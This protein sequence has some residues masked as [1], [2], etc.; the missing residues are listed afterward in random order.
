MVPWNRIECWPARALMVAGRRTPLLSEATA[1]VV[2]E[3]ETPWAASL[4]SQVNEPPAFTVFGAQDKERAGVAAAV[5]KFA[6]CAA[7]AVSAIAVFPP[8]AGLTVAATTVGVVEGTVL[9]TTS[10]Q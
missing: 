7:G 8:V 5:R 9:K 2:V 1:M 3:G 6:L 4:N 10:T